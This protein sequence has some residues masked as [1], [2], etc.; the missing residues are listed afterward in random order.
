MTTISVTEP[1][2]P[3]DR[4]ARLH[5]AME[6]VNGILL[7]KDGPVKPAFASLLRETLRRLHR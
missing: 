2:S 1:L 7:G 5:D 3:S 4:R 6:S